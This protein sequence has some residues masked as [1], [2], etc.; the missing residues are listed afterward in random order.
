MEQELI[1]T[2]GD[3]A[4][5]A[6]DKLR[7]EIT[8]L[9]LAVEKLA[10]EPTKIVIP[11][12]TET[13]ETVAEQMQ[14]NAD[15]LAKW[16]EKPALRLT[17]QALSDAIIKAGSDARAEDHAALTKATT[18]IE[19]E[20]RAVSAALAGARTATEQRKMLHRT[21]YGGVFAGAFLWATCA[22]FIARSLPQ[23]WHL[24][25]RMAAQTLRLD[26]WEAGS[27]LMEASNPDGWHRVVRVA[28]IES[29]NRQVIESCFKLAR[30]R[31]TNINCS[32]TVNADQPE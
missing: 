19:R 30:K 3:E 26:M 11:D 27:R 7:R 23:S 25:E 9:R 17:P 2:T 10:D 21:A 14:A 22:G 13:L 29:D 12:Y 15:Q 6:F 4:G 5:K 8:T 20:A 24:P 1:E 31:Q 32:I 28:R 16:A 18:A